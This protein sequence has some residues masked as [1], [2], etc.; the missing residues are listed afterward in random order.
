MV[1]N[2]L[3]GMILS[4]GVCT[5]I[6]LLA[7]NNIVVTFFAMVSIVVIVGSVLACLEFLGWSLGTTESIACIIVVGFS[8]DYVVHLGNSYLENT[9]KTRFLRCEE[10]LL[11]MGISVV[12]GAITTI[13]AGMFLFGCQLIFF[14]KF[15]AILVLTIA[16]SVIISMTF[17]LACLHVF[18]PENECGK[19]SAIFKRDNKDKN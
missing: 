6:L 11:N 10:A 3:S 14:N 18:G 1:K 16:F 7:T 4:F 19:I 9:K 12:G 17:F 2:V 13:G 8:I 15:G 5:F